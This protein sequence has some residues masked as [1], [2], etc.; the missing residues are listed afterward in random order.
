MNAVVFLVPAIFDILLSVLVLRILLQLSR[1]NFYNPISQLIWRASQ[2]VVGPLARFIPRWRTFD[3]AG[4]L[5][6]LAA[7]CVYVWLLNAVLPE[8]FIVTSP[9]MGLKLALLVIV[10]L[11]AKLYA[12]S[13]FAQALL[14]WVGSGVSNPN[15]NILFSLNEPLLRPVRRILPPFSGLDLSPIP[16]MLILLTIINVLAAELGNFH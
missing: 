3:I 11:V 8:V 7:T 5:V 6:L 13:I 1:A 12:L 2:P 16:V 15:A 9:A 10:N 14:S 4:A